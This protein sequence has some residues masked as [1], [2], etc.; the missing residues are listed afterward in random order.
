[1]RR[2]IELLGACV[3]VCAL[4]SAL[5]AQVR[6]SPPAGQQRMQGTREMHVAC[7]G[8]DTTR[9]FR[10]GIGD[11]LRVTQRLPGDTVRQITGGTPRSHEFPEFDVV[12][13]IPNVCVERIFLKV[14]SVTARLNLNAQIS[15]LVRVSAGADVLIGVVDLTIQDVRAKALL[16]VDLDDVV[17]IV[18]QTLTFVDNHPEII[19][20]LGSTLQNTVGA[21]GGAVGTLLR[22]LVIGVTR[23][24]NGNLLQRVVDEATG[25]ILQRT[26]SAAGA[27][28][29]QQ[30]VG[31][32]LRLPTIRQTTN[33]AGNIVRQVRDTAGALLEYTLD[34]ATNKL[35]GVRLL[36]A[37]AGAVR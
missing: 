17:H 7:V 19:Q 26:V 35:L 2:T 25:N 5:S 10:R 9:A 23:L 4:T 33:A 13:D 12:L 20:Q 18:D 29:S 22:G 6:P 1:M 15:N 21:V 37:A 8:P 31:S 32:I 24:A 34:K 27:Q 11:T 3:G 16:L 14:D 36:Q 28:L 30:V